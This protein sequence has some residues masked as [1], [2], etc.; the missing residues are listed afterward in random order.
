MDSGVVPLAEAR[1]PSVYGGKAVALGAGLRAG[2]PVPPGVALS[3]TLVDELASGSADALE[4]VLRS[5]H[6]PAG[7]LAARSSAVGEDSEAASFAGQHA[8]VLNVAPPGV[9]AA[10]CAV[11]QSAR[12]D[13]A[14]AYRQR[15]GLSGEPAIAVVVQQ[16]VE[17]LAAGVLFTRNPVNGA[18]E[19]IIEASWG[20]GEAVVAGL[21]S[22]DR[23]RVDP[24][25]AELER[26]PGHKDVKVWYD[27][28]HGTTEVAVPD[29]LHRTL[30]LTPQHV[31]QLHALAEQCRAVW[32]TEL[33]LEWAV[34]A[35][36]TV[37]LLQ[38]RPITTIRPPGA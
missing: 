4:R 20:L 26:T 33:D 14:L 15:K 32:R 13:A 24:S 8:T 11:W 10:V 31:R 21:V 3:C 16:L 7:R 12:S 9:G 37:Y 38:S 19:R 29:H 17:P 18:D 28:A 30:C 5:P 6:L 2:L 34:H 36:G 27:G 23:Y 35:D 22:P 1:D 25:G